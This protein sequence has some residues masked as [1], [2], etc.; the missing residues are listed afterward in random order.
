ML[1]NNSSPSRMYVAICIDADGSHYFKKFSLP[2][3]EQNDSENASWY[4]LNR[5]N[6]TAA[7]V[8]VV[9]FED[10]SNITEQKGYF[11]DEEHLEG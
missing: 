4:F 3:K 6:L 5:L 10:Y 8:G 11:D 9:T 2:E 1:N 7:I